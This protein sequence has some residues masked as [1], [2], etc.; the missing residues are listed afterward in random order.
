MHTL[1][2]VKNRLWEEFENLDEDTVDLVLDAT[3]D[4]LGLPRQGRLI[5]CRGD[6]KNEFKVGATELTATVL[7]ENDDENLRNLNHMKDG[8]VTMLSLE[9]A[10][11]MQ[12]EME[13]AAAG[14]EGNGESAE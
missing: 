12:L 4:V 7:V 6:M 11:Q 14:S 9:Q 5:V 13:A 1:Q 3:A 2:D 10:E 8:T